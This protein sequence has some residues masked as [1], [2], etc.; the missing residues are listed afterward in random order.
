MSTFVQSY[1]WCFF[2]KFK[3]V[4][5]KI[6]YCFLSQLFN[7]YQNKAAKTRILEFSGLLL[8]EG[9]CKICTSVQNCTRGQN[10][11]KTLLHEQTFLQEDI[12]AA[13]FFCIIDLLFDLVLFFTITVTP[14]PRAVSYSFNFKKLLFTI[15][16]TP[17]PRSVAFII[18][19]FFVIILSYFFFNYHGYP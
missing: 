14:Y 17:Y 5:N 1:F 19:I 13:N 7:R 11:T 9:S 6:D 3:F 4:K 16:V 15:S 2:R 18:I 12:F 8:F 10:C